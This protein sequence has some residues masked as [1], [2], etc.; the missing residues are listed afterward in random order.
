MRLA[1]S[2][3]SLMLTS[4]YHFLS[5]DNHVKSFSSCMMCLN[6]IVLLSLLRAFEIIQKFK[7]SNTHSSFPIIVDLPAPA[8][9]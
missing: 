2:T 1:Q 9:E 4:L 7:N 5:S 8:L 6:R 3:A